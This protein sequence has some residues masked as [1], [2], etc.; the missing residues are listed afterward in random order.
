MITRRQFLRGAGAVALVA[1]FDPDGR[2]WVT[3]AEASQCSTFADA[4][5]LDGVLL[6]DSASR[7]A[8]ASDKGNI[9]HR[10]PCAVLRPGS[11]ED[12]RRMIRY[13][14]QHGIRV[15]PRGQAHTS[16][17]QGL[18]D[19]LV[20]ENQYLDEIHALGPAGADVDSGI[21]WKDLVTAAYEHEPRLTPPVLTGYTALTVGGTLSVGGVGGLVGALSTGLQ[22]D[23]AREL[24]VVTG[25]GD[26]RT[27]SATHQRDL[28]EAALGG[29]GQCGVITRA[30]L[31][32]VPAKG[33]AR[34]YL[35][36]YTDNAA[37]FADFRKLV[38]RPGLDHVYTLWFPPGTTSLI[39]QINATVFYDPSAPPND[40]QLAG[41]LSTAP[42]LQDSTY[43]DYVFAVDHVVD[44]FRATLD[45]DRL[46]KPWFDVWLP[47]S[48]VERYVGEVIPNLTHDDIGSTGFILLF[49]QRRALATRPF[50]RLPEPDGSPW[51]FLFDILT[52][53]ETTQPSR[54][55]KAGMIER[56][57]RL[58]RQ[59]RE[60]FGGV[61]YPIG[62]MTFTKDDWRTHYGDQWQAF[63]SRKQRF[64]PDGILTPGPNIFA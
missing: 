20:I 17:G 10:M 1:G 53:S 48:T 46:V 43:L 26:I 64:D 27:C 7:Q 8:V 54:D 35:F 56:N 3:V 41:G 13:C 32:L 15:S 4:P 2:R 37:F 11:A 31:D 57:D 59:A 16:H 36:H 28:F 60:S 14:R 5:A 29:L 39:Y 12:V 6:V 19:G 55:F 25:R 9:I 40:L 42:Q 61:R 44:A 24:E 23:H 33:R 38:N 22:V 30:K 63:V 34:T 49:P 21:R 52:A 62:T 58:F 47:D 18:S 51:V 45:W 50:L